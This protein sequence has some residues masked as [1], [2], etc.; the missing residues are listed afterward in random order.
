M[1]SFQRCQHA[2]WL[3][4]RS[5]GLRCECASVSVNFRDKG[6]NLL[7]AMHWPEVGLVESGMCV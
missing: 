4:Q 5:G 7:H 2:A 6:P 1:E 3:M